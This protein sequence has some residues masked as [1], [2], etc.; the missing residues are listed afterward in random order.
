VRFTRRNLVFVY[1]KQILNYSAADLRRSSLIFFYYNSSA[2]LLIIY[3]YS[4]HALLPSADKAQDIENRKEN[5]T[6]MLCDEQ[7]HKNF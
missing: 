6:L 4:P 1:I 5:K 3:K 2:Y 7:C